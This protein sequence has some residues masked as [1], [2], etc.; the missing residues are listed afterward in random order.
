MVEIKPN[1][2]SKPPL[3]RHHGPRFYVNDL[4]EVHWDGHPICKCTIKTSEEIDGLQV[5]KLLKENGE[6]YEEGVWVEEKY[7]FPGEGV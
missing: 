1:F 2:I 3:E 4:V 5:Y 6:D 7:L